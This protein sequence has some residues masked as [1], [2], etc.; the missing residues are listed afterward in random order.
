MGYE[1]KKVIE[2]GQEN[3]KPVGLM[4]GAILLKDGKEQVLQLK[5]RNNGKN[6]LTRATVKITCIGKDGEKIGEQSYT[7]EKLFVTSDTE[8]G[9]DVAIPLKYEN[10]VSVAVE[11]ERDLERLKVS[12]KNTL[13]NEW[14][15]TWFPKTYNVSMPL[16]AMFFLIYHIIALINWNLLTKGQCLF[17][18]WGSGYGSFMFQRASAITLTTAIYLYP[19]TQVILSKNQI[20]YRQLLISNI[21]Q[22]LAFLLIVRVDSVASMAGA[23]GQYYLCLT[24]SL[25]VVLIH[26]VMIEDIRN[27]MYILLIGIAMVLIAFIYYKSNAWMNLRGS[28]LVIICEYLKLG[29]NIIG[30]FIIIKKKFK[31]I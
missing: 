22:I 9:T 26:V 19:M 11:I 10:V 1:V 21:V 16:L 27:K 17:L 8:F 3:T 14:N 29:I 28:N 12:S 31:L 20:N 30:I 23:S 2:F 5:L 4:K 13:K 6:I 25:A 15:P 24:V 18:F 7:Y